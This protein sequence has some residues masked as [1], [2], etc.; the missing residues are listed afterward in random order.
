MKLPITGQFL[1]DMYQVFEDS[2]KIK[3]LIFSPT[4]AKLDIWLDLQ[5]PIFRKYKDAKNRRAFGNAVHYLKRKNYIRVQSLGGK[6]A[7]MLTKEGFSK[8][9]KASFV[10]EDKK[11]RADKKWIMVIFD[12]PQK[13][14]KARNL[15]KSI[16]QNLGYKLLQQ[17]VWVNPYDVFE[18]TEIIFRLH[19]LDKYIKIF[20]VEDI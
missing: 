14:R 18:K 6:K 20:L 3:D 1:W 8:A 13:H 10:A 15:L 7:M 11:K 16:L 5:N 12:V 4:H 17:S 2:G 19:S 9:L